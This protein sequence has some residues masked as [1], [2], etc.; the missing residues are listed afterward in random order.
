MSAAATIQAHAG[1]SII[2]AVSVVDH[3]G[4]AKV[5]DGALS[6]TFILIVGGTTVV[7]RRGSGIS[8]SG[9]TVTV[10]VQ[11]SDTA[12]VAAGTYD[13]QLFVV[14]AASTTACVLYGSLRLLA[15]LDTTGEVVDIPDGDHYDDGAFY[16]GF[17]LKN[18][19][20][21][22]WAS[23]F[24]GEDGGDVTLRVKTGT[25]LVEATPTSESDGSAIAV[26][27]SED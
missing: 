17:V 8:I 5:L 6:A 4:A 21:D 25:T 7:K 27:E 23:L 20:E 3:T 2:L 15:S 22:K 14:D 1:E 11:A 18:E 24:L 16:A 9:S 10:T 12:S 19:D 13:Y 26:G